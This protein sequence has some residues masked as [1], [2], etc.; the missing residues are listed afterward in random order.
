MQHTAPITRLAA[1]D[2]FAYGLQADENCLLGSQTRFEN[3][4]CIYA[5]RLKDCTMG[6]FM[7]FNAAGATSAYRTQF[8]RY[9]QIGESSVIGPPEHPQDWFSSHPFTF[10]RPQ[11]MPNYYR[12]PAFA[13]LAPDE[14]DGPSFVDGVVND[15]WIG[16]EAYIGIGSFVKRGVR[17]GDGATVGAHSVVTRDIPAYAV[18][19][20]SPARV[21]RLRFTE[22]IVERLLALQWWRYD[23]APFKHQV[24]YSKVEATLDF[25]EECRADGRLQD[26]RPDSYHVERKAEGFELTRLPQPLFFT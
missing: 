4:S 10:T 11:Y 23:L 26:L 20:G 7:Y 3:P 24:D 14:Q 21:L 19:V 25:F 9:S 1:A 2:L 22:N 15:T 5:H 16:H 13:R 8:G 12:M 17:V 6:A 18:A